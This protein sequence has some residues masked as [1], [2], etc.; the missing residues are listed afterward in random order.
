MIYLCLFVCSYK[1]IR[2][3]ST[4]TAYTADLSILSRIPYSLEYL[5]QYSPHALCGGRS[6]TGLPVSVVCSCLHLIISSNYE[7]YVII[8]RFVF[9]RVVLRLD[10]PEHGG[11]QGFAYRDIYPK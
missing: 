3:A 11:H 6:R 9:V 1:S 2:R 8:K 7:T 4:S 5:L 10:S